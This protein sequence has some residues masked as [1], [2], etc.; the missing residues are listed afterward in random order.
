L[1]VLGR[2]VLA[3]QS[4]KPKPAVPIDPIAGILGAFGSHSIV[5]LGEGPHHN[6]QGHLFRLALLRDARFART[7]ND[8]VVECG[9]AQYQDTMDRFI[10]GEDVPY[11]ELRKVWQDVSE[12]QATWDVPIYE[13]FYRAVREVNASLPKRRQLRVL[14]G[15][16]PFDWDRVR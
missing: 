10:R 16:T 12:P 2:P 4:E 8:I 13:E 1:C 9:N 6:I 7:V 14:L 11:A 3:E 5:A 15:N